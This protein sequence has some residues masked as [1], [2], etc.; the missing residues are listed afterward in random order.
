MTPSQPS[1]G[2]LAGVASRVDALLRARGRFA[3][4]ADRPPW[5]TLVAVLVVAGLCYGAVMGLYGA[6]ALQ[7]L[8]SAL[9][10]PM[11]LTCATLVCLP[12]FFVVNTLLG[13]R[14]DFAAAVRGVLAAQAAVSLALAAL[15]PLTAF[16]YVNAIRYDTALLLN[17]AVFAAAAG[18]GQALLQRHYRALIARDPRHKV[19]RAAWLVLYCFVAIQ[20]AWVLRP[21]VGSPGL[22]VAFFREDAWSNAYVVLWKLVARVLSGA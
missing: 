22:P 9:K 16:A 10:V 7:A 13:L 8:Y 20:L 12:N 19:A 4:D 17:G 18:G 3:P 11:L 6:R 2:A 21:F 14:D 5:G 15:G 1:S